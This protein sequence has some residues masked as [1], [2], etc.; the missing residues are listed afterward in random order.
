MN[1]QHNLPNDVFRPL[2]VCKLSNATILKVESVTFCLL[3]KFSFVLLHSHLLELGGNLEDNDIG[4]FMEGPPRTFIFY[5]GETF[6][7]DKK[8]SRIYEPDNTEVLMGIDEDTLDVFFV[9]GYYKELGYA[10]GIYVGG[11][12]LGSR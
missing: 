5:H 11:K 4:L 3:N 10:G 6:K 1:W 12:F 9:K 7:N 2:R 8:G